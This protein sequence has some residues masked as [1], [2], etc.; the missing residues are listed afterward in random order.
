MFFGMG[1]HVIHLPK[2]TIEQTPYIQLISN[3]SFKFLRHT[4][5]HDPLAYIHVHNLLNLSIEI[6]HFPN[7]ANFNLAHSVFNLQIYLF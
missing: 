7:L 2:V 1:I 5:I 3:K 6:H 4:Y